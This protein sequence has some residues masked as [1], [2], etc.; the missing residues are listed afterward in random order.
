QVT[1]PD[2]NSIYGTGFDVLHLN[3]EL[4]EHEK[5]MLFLSGDEDIDADVTKCIS[6]AGVDVETVHPPAEQL[7]SEL[8]DANDEPLVLTKAHR[9]AIC[10]RQAGGMHSETQGKNAVMQWLR[11]TYAPHAQ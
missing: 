11:K 9:R 1:A 6:E 8:V 7:T 2:W 10:F 3:S 5:P 4:A